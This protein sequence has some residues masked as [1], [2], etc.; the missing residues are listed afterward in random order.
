MS[1]RE[2]DGGGGDK[3][4]ENSQGTYELTRLVLGVFLAMP[5]L[6]LSSAVFSG[7]QQGLWSHVH[8]SGCCTSQLPK[9]VCAVI[10]GEL[11][12][13]RGGCKGFVGRIS[14]QNH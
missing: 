5:H 9:T 7:A 10:S 1:L 6:V 4:T 11:A 3:S 8:R 12:T 14:S 13:V 2:K